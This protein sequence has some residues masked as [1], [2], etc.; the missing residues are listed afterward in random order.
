MNARRLAA[1]AAPLA[2]LLPGALAAQSGLYAP[3]VLQLPS[4]ARTLGLGNTGVASRDDEVIFFNPAQV[5]N[6][7]GT[8]VSAERYSATAGGGS[9]SS[10][11]AFANGGVA[12]G[13]RVVNYEVPTNFFP[14]D[15]SSMLGEGSPATSYE[16]SVAFAQTVKSVRGGITA[17]Y[18]EDIA[19]DIRVSRP[20][21]DL[22]LARDFFRSYTVGLSVQSIGKSMDIPCGFNHGGPVCPT[23]PGAVRD[24]VTGSAFRDAGG[25][26]A[27]DSPLRTTLGV[28]TTKSVGEFDIF[29]TAAV[30]MLRTDFVIPSGGLEVNY[31]WLSGYN[32]ALR[33]GARRPIVGEDPITAGAGFTMDRLT[34]DYAL[35]T[36]SA[37]RVAHRIGVRVR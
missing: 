21:L 5:A 31:S 28:S 20:L 30:S 23:V 24:S 26:V 14:A 29:G 8:T 19:P 36:L 13:A 27:A 32:I 15:R 12:I 22:G 10:A 7:R 2:L 25:S 37:G 4:G 17:K 11:M 18:A 9:L 6:A 1:L 33:A 16:A 34:I 3:L 35:E